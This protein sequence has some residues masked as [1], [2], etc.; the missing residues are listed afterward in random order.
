MGRYVFLCVVQILCSGL[1][2]GQEGALEPPLVGRPADFSN[3]VGRYERPKIHVEPTEVRI[4]DAITL[5]ITI[6]GAGPRQYEPNRKNLKLFPETFENDFFVQE[7]PDEHKVDPRAKTWFFVYRLKPRHRKV[8]EIDGIRLTF[9]N[10]DYPGRQKYLRFF[11]EPMPISIKV[12]PKAPAPDPELPVDSTPASF[13]SIADARR[14]MAQPRKWSPSGRQIS[15]LLA[16]PPLFCLAGV[17]LWR[18]TFSHAEGRAR[19]LRRIEARQLISRLMVNTAPWKLVREYLAD[20][21]FAAIDATP[22]EVAAFLKRRGFARAVCEQA[23]AFFEQCDAERFSPNKP[24]PHVSEEAIRLLEALEAD[25]C[26]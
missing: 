18:R 13:Y 23:R 12:K 15:V 24:A 7:L 19:Q 3:V 10:P 17:F 2:F 9:Y 16:L 21:G 25:P 4:E 6:T 20:R 11:A 8:T 5:K 26:V 22:V 14:V 1:L